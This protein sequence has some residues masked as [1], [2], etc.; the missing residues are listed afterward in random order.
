MVSAVTLMPDLRAAVLGNY[1]ATDLKLS[2]S[3]AFSARL[4]EV[5][6]IF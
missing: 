2:T 3:W 5:L 1:M 4:F 6:L